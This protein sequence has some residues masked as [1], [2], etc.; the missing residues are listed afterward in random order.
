MKILVYL[1]HPAHFH[2][3]KNTLLFLK[4]NK[5]DIVITMKT[6]DVLEELLIE[7]NMSYVNIQEKG[8]RGSKLGL[9][10]GLVQRWYNHCKLMKNN[11]FDI[12]ISSAGE[13]APFTKLFNIP[14]INVFEDDLTL[15]PLYSK[16]IIPFVDCLVVPEVCNT[17]G[18]DS[19]AIFYSGNQELAY[20]HPSV[21]KPDI[22][23]AQKY[24]DISRKNFIIRFSK[25]D[26][27]HD[28]GRTG[29]TE[30][31]FNH[32]IEIIKNEG[33]IL[34]TAEGDLKPE[35][36]TYRL[37]IPARDIHHILYFADL[38]IGDSQTMTAEA[39]VLGTPSI[40]FNDFV[41]E[42]G[43]LEE[44]ETKYKLAYGIKTTSVELF[45]ATVKQLIS[46]DIKNQFKVRRSNFLKDKIVVSS[47]LNWVI[48]NYPKS[49][50]IM[51]EK[52]AYQNRFRQC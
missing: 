27:W 30:Q 15:F 19:K 24:I 17:N 48:E 52:P 12:A 35:Y 51:K 46:S 49:T 25:L 23:I 45:Y 18:W 43:Y 40:R 1:A 14:F 8:R 16:L 42:I 6:K 39:S 2:L 38:F 28:S 11:K 5:H 26:A 10:K 4:K 13:I 50:K 20:L 32:L 33:N 36:M 37:N 7:N 21:F 3:F 34:I 31:V 22:K 41:G 29:I 47:F 9:A 44:L